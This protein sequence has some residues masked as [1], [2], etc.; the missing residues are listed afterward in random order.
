[1]AS[2]EKSIEDLSQIRNIMERSTQFLSLSGLSGVFAGVYALIAAW[3]VYYD[4]A[5]RTT[6]NYFGYSE[7]IKAGVEAEYISDKVNYAF[8]V[9]LIV[10]AASL[11]TGFV[12]TKQK[13]KKS[14]QTLV[15]NASKRMLFSLLIPLLAGGIFC[16]ALLQQNNI[17]LIAPTTLIFYGLA[18]I[19]ASK[20]T[21]RDIQYLGILEVLLGLVSAF[22]IGYG[23]IFWA[24]GFGLLHIVYGLTMYVKYDR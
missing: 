13:S 14:G 16:F 23:L 4:F 24:V 12:F 10:L 21:L 18:L 3:F 6:S 19:N 7:I 5:E 8:T 20:H 11:I 15:N 2:K 17:G 1:M 9:G 22:F